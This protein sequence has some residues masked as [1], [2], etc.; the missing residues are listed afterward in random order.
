MARIPG[1]EFLMGSDRFYPEE[2]PAHRVAV[3]PFW[4]DA[5]PVT[6]DEFARFVAATGHVTVAEIAPD[7]AEYPDADP[8][9]LVPGSLV[10]RP[11]TG[12]VDLRDVRNWWHWVP[13]AQ[14]RHPE[15]PG[16]EVA[17]RG[18]HP[19][20]QVAFA[21]AEA[22]AR[23]AGKA[24]PTEAE[25]ELAARGGLEGADYIWG[26][27]PDADA[28]L[29]NTWRGEFPWRNRAAGGW[30]TTSPVGSYPPNGHGLHD[31]SG[32]VWEW[33]LDYFAPRHPGDEPKAC[34]VPR[35]PRVAS[36]D[37]S[38]DVGMPGAHIPRRVLKGGSHLCAPSYCLRYRPAAR[39]AE[40]VDT[41]TTHI[42]FRCVVREA[43][44]PAG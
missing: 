11:T 20:T 39:Q 3:D 38:F 7:P 44:A 10:F 35:N 9:L 4:I 25:W 23:W 15:G 31:M 29:A 13:G 42:G 34:C 28:R 36:P 27:D 32:N 22:Y 17:G 2:G 19:V 21:D 12:P 18:G 43:V 30:D 40:A 16:S 1:G 33:T 41:S 14:W 24:L 5:H 6:V 26:D 8:D 37:R